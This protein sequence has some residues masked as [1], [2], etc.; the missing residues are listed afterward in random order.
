MHFVSKLKTIFI[1]YLKVLW[2]MK[3]MVLISQSL[4]AVI[5]DS[6]SNVITVKCVISLLLKRRKNLYLYIEYSLNKDK[7]FL[8]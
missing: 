4:F 8:Y 3:Y 2:V 1:T 6:L 5:P 7:F